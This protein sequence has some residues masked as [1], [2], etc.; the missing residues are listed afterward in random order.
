MSV[1]A[2]LADRDGDGVPDRM[3]ETVE[4]VGTLITDPV[5]ASRNSARAHLQDRTG[6]VA[7]FTHDRAALLGRAERGDSIRVRGTV[8]QFRGADELVVESTERLSAGTV[9]PPRD[10]LAAEVKSE[11]N[12][13]R[14]VRLVGEIR[15]SEAVDGALDVEIA[16]RSGSV[17]VYLPRRFLND[18]GFVERLRRGGEAV[19][20]GIASHRRAGPHPGAGHEIV[21]RDPEDISLS[22]IPPYRELALLAGFLLLAA[23]AL[24]FWLRRR[25]AERRAREMETL[26][27]EL[28]EAKTAL[29]RERIYLRAVIDATPNGV[30]VKDHSGRFTLANTAMASFY[31]LPPEEIVGRS[32]LELGIPPER[33]REFLARDGEVIRTGRSI[34][35]EGEA[36]RSPVTGETHWFDTRKVPLDDPGGERHVLGVAIDVTERRET[37]ERLRKQ[38]VAMDASMDGMAVLDASGRYV[39][40]NPAHAQIYGYSDPRELIG[41]SWK[42]L[43]SEAEVQRI[44]AAI[45]LVVE[46]EGGWR[47]EAIGTRLD[48]ST[49]PQ[50]ISLTMLEGG[51]V[52]CVVRDVTERKQ[53]EDQLRH[54]QKMEAVGR[55][56]GGV[57]HDFNNLLLVIRGN[58]SLALESLPEDDPTREDLQEIERASERAANLVR[59]LLAF[60]RAQSTRL[61]A[62]DLNAVVDGTEKMLRRLIGADVD[63]VTRLDPGVGRVHAD[64]GQVEQVL[65]NLAVNARDAMP[66]GGTLLIETGDATVDAERARDSRRAKPGEY[67][68]VRMSDTGTGM[69]RATMERIFEPFFTT[70]EQGKGTGLGLSIVYGIVEQSGGFIEVESREGQGT[71]FR[72]YL[73]RLRAESTG[74]GAQ[75]EV[76]AAPRPPRG[77]ETI[78]VVDDESGVRRLAAR[79]LARSGYAILEASNGEEAL[80]LAA[81]HEKP[82]HLLLTDLSM[83]VMGGRELA[84]RMASSHPGV[85]VVYMSG[86]SEES[87]DPGIARTMRGPLL[88]KPF[89]PDSLARVV[90]E[91]LDS[92][93]AGR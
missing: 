15:V 88:A 64:S 69:D 10:V 26:A 29:E 22:P 92:V 6:G 75:T 37:G 74:T 41:R 19:V 13:G 84:E 2:A 35:I 51:G 52:V 40:L 16:D 45:S 7:L 65:V 90:R 54:S 89:D 61:E 77:S 20:V 3:G 34:S 78:L 53:L 83:P 12:S 30:F 44:E 5:P 38:S 1:R 62:L 25:S 31:G 81:A 21:P 73:P 17:R 36:V 8:G 72:V 49:F 43:Y 39:Y 4:V 56:A 91:V 50:E 42:D 57:A 93:E 82:I 87:L 60:S 9:P 70:K 47:G 63:L 33:A 68:M 55:L 14:L 28:R 23:T 18:P 58:A 67:A 24:F 80:R 71:S 11:W 76:G 48:G 79:I 46:E 86:Y 85:P 66:G 27:R 32:E 59:Q